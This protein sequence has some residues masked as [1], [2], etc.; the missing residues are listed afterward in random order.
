MGFGFSS[1]D[2]QRAYLGPRLKHYHPRFRTGGQLYV[3]AISSHLNPGATVVDLGCGHGGLI[4]QLRPRISQLIGIDVDANAVAKNDLL[5]QRIVGNV[6]SIPLPSASVDGVVSEF[7]LE[8]LE[9]PARVLTEVFRI[10]K[11][12][13]W[14]IALTPNVLNPVMLMSRLLPHRTHDVLRQSLLHKSEAAHRT[15]YR[16]NTAGR[17]KQLSSEVGF[18]SATIQRAGNPE[19]LAFA[20]VLAVP[21][22]LG[23]RFIDRPVLNQLQMYLVAMMQK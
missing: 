22:I 4:E 3:E 14:F 10:L 5:D 12:G 20:K 2:E 21:S 6:E 17:I 9:H 8:H 23:E 13:G 16:A 15:F 18:Q 1:V 7:A 19:Y 11:P